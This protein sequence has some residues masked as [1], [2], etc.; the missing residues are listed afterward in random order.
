MRLVAS[1]DVD[2]PVGAGDGQPAQADR[3]DHREQRVVH[4]DPECEGEH[5]DHRHAP[6][7]HQQ[8]RGKADVVREIVRPSS[9]TGIA[10]G[11]FDR[12]GPAEFRARAPARVRFGE[13]LGDVVGDQ[14][15]EME[16]ELGIQFV[17]EPPAAAQALPPGHEAPPPSAARRMS[18]IATESRSQF[19]VSDLRYA[20]PFGVRR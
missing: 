1:G 2:D 11:V 4:A 17:F 16:P 12:L 18:R 3:V 14:A 7:L 20:R 19:A 6:R 15:V 9:A 5:G 13:T 8:A 10:A